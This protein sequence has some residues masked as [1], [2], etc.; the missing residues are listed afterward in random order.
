MQMKSKVVQIGL[1]NHRTF[2]KVT[3][4]DEENVI[5]VRCA[6]RSAQRLE[7]GRKERYTCNENRGFSA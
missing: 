1:D 4:R 2:G 6:E 5:G 7:N 3:A